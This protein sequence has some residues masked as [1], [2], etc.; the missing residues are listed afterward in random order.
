MKGRLVLPIA[1]AG[2]AAW[3]V[4]LGAL[5]VLISSAGLDYIFQDTYFLAPHWRYMAS[6]IAACVVF[7]LVYLAIPPSGRLQ[8]GLG[9][10]HLAGIAVGFTLMIAPP[11]LMGAQGMPRRIVDYP[12]GYEAT[13][14]AIQIGY[15][16]SLLSLA[17]FVALL[18]LKAVQATRARLS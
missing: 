11:F 17:P 7:G 16:L 4:L 2:V 3:V 5:A 1:W 9:S 15:W 18:A 10:A 12:A 8:L 14:K 6:F 13:L